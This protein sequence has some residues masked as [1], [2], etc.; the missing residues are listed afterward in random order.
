[1]KRIFLVSTLLLLLLA[2]VGCE[3]EENKDKIKLS[4]V[5]IVKELRVNAGSCKNGEIVVINSQKELND[6]YKNS[7]VPKDLNN[8]DFNKNSVIIGSYGTTRGVY[9]IKHNFSKV[10][11][12]Y[13]YTLTITLDDTDVAQGVGF[14]IIIEKIPS[15]SEIIFKVNVIND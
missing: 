11:D 1:M 2:I 9:K 4:D 7:S 13:E 8:I 6:I 5:K 15:N 14:G 3:K 10:G 12:K